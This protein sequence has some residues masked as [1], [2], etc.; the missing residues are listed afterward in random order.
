VVQET[1]VKSETK[2]VGSAIKGT[3]K[4][5]ADLVTLHPINAATDLG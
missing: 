4:S 3:G 2:G 5:A 1:S